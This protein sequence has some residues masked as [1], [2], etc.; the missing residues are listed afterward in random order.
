GFAHRGRTLAGAM[1]Q[2]FTGETF[3]ALPGEA[4]HARNGLRTA[5]R[6]S[7]RTSLAEARLFTTT[8]ALFDTEARQTAWQALE[9]RALQA[10]YGC[11]CYAY[12][13]LAAGHADLVV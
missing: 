7:G 10:R 2:P 8:P 13:L 3:L 11:D 12:C 5:L 1:S 6:T 9:A 4:V